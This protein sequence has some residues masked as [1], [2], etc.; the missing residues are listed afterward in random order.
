MLFL[1]SHKAERL[2]RKLSYIDRLIFIIKYS[3]NS[4]SKL[5]ILDFND[6]LPFFIHYCQDMRVIR[7]I[8]DFI[9]VTES[10]RSHIIE[11]FVH[12]CFFQNSWGLLSIFEKSLGNHIVEDYLKCK[13]QKDQQ[14]DCR[15]IPSAQNPLDNE[16]NL[17]DKWN[18]QVVHPRSDI[19]FIKAED[20]ADSKHPNWHLEVD[21]HCVRQKSYNFFIQCLI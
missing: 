13:Y 6:K 11:L 1:F 9:R 20:R 7:V 8:L 10:F 16:S 12:G 14:K 4:R 18:A 17:F 5:K 3:N 15:I 19:W 2:R 21:H